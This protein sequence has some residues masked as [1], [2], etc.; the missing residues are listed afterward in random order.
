MTQDQ[1]QTQTPAMPSESDL[2]D[3]DQ[4]QDWGHSPVKDD[5]DTHPDDGKGVDSL[6]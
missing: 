3:S 6:E 4:T 2:K 5:N 1:D